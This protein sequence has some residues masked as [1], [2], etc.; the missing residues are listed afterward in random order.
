M[1][2][3]ETAFERLYVLIK[4][5]RWKKSQLCVISEKG[6]VVPIHA[7]ET[8]RGIGGIASIILKLGNTWR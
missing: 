6:K 4:R 7:M 3:I 2:E 1:R 5:R 8:Y